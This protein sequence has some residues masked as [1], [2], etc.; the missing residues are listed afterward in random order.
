MDFIENTSKE[1]EAQINNIDKFNRTILD[2]L[3]TTNIQII[4]GITANIDNFNTDMIQSFDDL[5]KILGIANKSVKETRNF[6]DKP[7]SRQ[8]NP[9]NE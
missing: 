1:I 3:S 7:K 5:A 4:E 2:T 6:R 8:V 9:Y